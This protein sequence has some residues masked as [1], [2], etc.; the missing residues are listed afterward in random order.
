MELEVLHP[1]RMAAAGAAR[2]RLLGTWPDSVTGA[3]DQV[4]VGRLGQGVVDGAGG[5]SASGA[6][7][8]GLADL[9]VRSGPAGSSSGLVWLTGDA[10]MG[11]SG[12]WPVMDTGAAAVLAATV[13]RLASAVGVTTSA[14]ITGRT[15]V[16]QAA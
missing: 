15:A 8:D 9:P 11:K 10:S 6:D 4:L 12:E 5:R 2:G 7:A 14:L 16:V 1:V 3:D 13:A